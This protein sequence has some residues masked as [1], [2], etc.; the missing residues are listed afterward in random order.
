[1]KSTSSKQKRIAIT[2]GCTVI[3]AVALWVLLLRPTWR[4]AQL[5]SQELSAA[6]IR[7]ETTKQKIRSADKLRI[8]LGELSQQL[9]AEREKLISGDRY[10]WVLRALN[11][12][13]DP[14]ELSFDFVDEPVSAKWPYPSVTPLE[15][16]SYLIKG[17]A[18]YQRLGLFL[19]EFENKYPG[20]R[21]TGLDLEPHKP[22]DDEQVDFTLHLTGII[23]RGKEPSKPSR[24]S[25]RTVA[26]HSR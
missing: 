13:K 18:S 25:I 16:A 20:L 23:A 14:G 8:E 19:A 15:G 17:V 22:L 26:N 4:A 2:I 21:F 24:T 10:L 5:R 6:K 9:D 3:G 7:L 11:E 1:M 12:Y